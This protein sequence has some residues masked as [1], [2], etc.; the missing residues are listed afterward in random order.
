MHIIYRNGEEWWK[1]RSELQKGLSS[2]K[3]VR[4]FL[5]LSDEIVTDFV[6]ALPRQ[7]D[8]NNQI[9]EM[10]NELNLLNLELLCKLVFDQRMNSFSN[11]QRHPESIVSQLINASEISN[12]TVLLTDQDFHLW[13]W[14]QTPDYKKL[15]QSQEFMERFAIEMVDK[16]MKQ[17]GD[18]NSLLEQYLN[19]PKLDVK[20][21]YGMACDLLLAGVHTTSYTLSF[22]LHYISSDH[23]VQ[24][25]IYAE[26]LKIL[27]NDGN[28]VTPTIMN[29]EIPYTRAVLKEVL[30]LNPVSIGVGRNLNRDKVLS[31]HHVPK[32]VN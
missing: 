19:N 14:F 16:K 3:N 11:D 12:D 7:F 15:R 17:T 25:L 8:Q 29:T 5:P 10:L 21:L 20:D 1:L 32:D 31:G 6:N 26:A 28:R 2:P 22:A 27:P 30:R 9:A 18:G 23:R 4:N 13:R 24:D